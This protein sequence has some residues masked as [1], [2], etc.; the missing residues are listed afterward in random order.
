M[1]F[2]Q[3]LV[4]G[5][6]QGLVVSMAAVSITLAFGIARFPNIAVGDLLTVGAFAAFFGIG[7]TG[8]MTAGVVTAALSSSAVSVI[9]YFAAYRQVRRGDVAVLMIASVGVAF[10][11]RAIVSLAFGHGQKT[12]ALPIGAPLRLGPI[13][14][15]SLDLLILAIALSSIAV[16]LSV[17]NWTAIGRQMRAVADNR[18]L[19]RVSGVRPGRVLVAMWAMSGAV[20]G[21]AGAML[22]IKTVVSPEIGWEMLL[23]ALAATILGGI[24]SPVGAVLAG[25]LLGALQEAA[26]PLVGFTYKLAIAFAV[27]LAVLLI[28]P[29][30]LLG[31]R[32]T[33][34]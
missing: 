18:D 19:A 15:S 22:G 4:N 30:G 32:E 33:I 26:T 20:A 25:V 27:M 12:I 9:V 29:S 6:F 3:L 7:M 11:L 8:T 5:A 28:R 17:L 14:I 10:L 23:P 2:L 31:R 16:L 34:R 1:F 21:I 24:G 13:S